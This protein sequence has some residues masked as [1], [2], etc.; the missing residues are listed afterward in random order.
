M[1]RALADAGYTRVPH[2]SDPPA[3]GLLSPGW[4]LTE[5]LLER[6]L[7]GAP[8]DRRDKILDQLDAIPLRVAA[9][10]HELEAAIRGGCEQLVVLG[11]GLDTRAF[12]MRALADVAVFEVDHPAT[13]AYKRRKVASLL[14][15]AKSVTFV[16]VDFE[17]AGLAESL[18]DAGFHRERPTA[19]VWE[20][21][22]MYLTDEAMRR[23]LDAVAACS[24]P[25]S[26]LLLHYIDRVPP[27]DAGQRRVRRALLGFWREPQIGLRSPEVMRAEVERVGFEVIDDCG[28]LEWA[29][30]LG[31][32]RP[33][34][35]MAAV[36]HLLV[37]ATSRRT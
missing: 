9:I 3:R 16:T 1:A 26:V 30:R 29:E 11:A 22:V 14:P 35:G 20:G 24:A 28:A 7:R 5:R 19:W 18:C 10:D 13:Q 17:R 32:K 6:M 31:A 37:A 8:P 12:R 36:F 21:V 4:A 2:F 33:A 27:A 15:R 25:G 34:G 23:T